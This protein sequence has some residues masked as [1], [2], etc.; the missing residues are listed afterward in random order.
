MLDLVDNWFQA[1]AGGLALDVYRQMRKEERTMQRFRGNSPL[2]GDCFHLFARDAAPT[3]SRCNGVSFS[4]ASV[5][6]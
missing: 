2:V 6:V 3:R 1:E 4:W 5:V